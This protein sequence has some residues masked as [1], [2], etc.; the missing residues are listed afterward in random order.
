MGG[1]G[2]E[3]DMVVSDSLKALTLYETIFGDAVERITVTDLTVGSN[4]AIF[5]IYGTRFHLLDENPQFGLNAPKADSE[6]PIWLNIT[7]PDIEKT[8]NTALDSGCMKIFPVTYVES[9][10]VKNAMFR[11]VFG[12]GW[13]LH[14]I[15]S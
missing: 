4:E 7:V 15:L 10:N 1:C 13:M 14:Q 11:D 2:V 3:I 12:H 6:M 5:T 8:F 9:H